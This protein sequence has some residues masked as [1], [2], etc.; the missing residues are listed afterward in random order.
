MVTENPQQP[1]SAQRLSGKSAA[2][3]GAAAGNGLAIAQRL[4]ADGVAVYLSD[5]DEELLKSVITGLRENGVDADGGVYDASSVTE[6]GR[7]IADAKTRLGR[8]DIFVNNAGGIRAQ[9]FPEVTEQTWDWSMDLNLKGAY[10]H[11]QEAAKVMA[12]QQ[13][14]TIINIASVAGIA[15]GMT[16]SPPYAASKAALINLTKVA[17]ANLASRG[18][19]VNAVAPGIVNTAFNWNLD[20]EIGVGQQ[21]RNPGDFL[22]ERVAP[23]PLG[24]ISEP[25]DVAGVVAFLAGPDGSYITGET[26][27][28]SGGLVMR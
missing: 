28:V 6:A 27:V 7:F 9:P 3:T 16:F 18:V 2:V 17:A 20:E 8:L 23:I 19:T 12:E 14:G 22:A 5:I 11:M 15:G 10:F 25:E 21:N 24:R 4:G 13:S 1:A 26:I